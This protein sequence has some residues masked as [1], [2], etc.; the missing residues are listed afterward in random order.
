M[1]ERLPTSR[2]TIIGGTPLLS[3]DVN[4]T[5]LMHTLGG[6]KTATRM[7]G[8]VG[9][10]VVLWVGG[11]RLDNVEIH[12]G[13]GV[14]MPAASG[15]AV[16]FYDTAVVVSGGPFFASGHKILAKIHPASLQGNN[17][18]AFFNSGLLSYGGQVNLGRV[19][20]SGLAVAVTSGQQGW[21]VSFSPTLSG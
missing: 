3:G 18:N 1:P 13:A 9:P 5:Q 6:T 12:P 19:F 4:T 8:L 2:P 15:I 11:G 20:T 14:T 16:T 21:T 17:F 7:S 10:D